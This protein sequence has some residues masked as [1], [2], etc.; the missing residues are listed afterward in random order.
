MKTNNKIQ[1]LVVILL[2]ALSLN[3]LA[4]GLFLIVDPSGTALQIPVELL[5]GTPF[6]SYLIP[7]IILF[8]TNG[9]SSL[10]IAIMTI[11]KVKHYPLLIILQGCVLLA[12]LSSELILNRE[13]FHPVLHYPLFVVGVLLIIAG[14]FVERKGLEIFARM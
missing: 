9:I 10:V 14:F 8:L 4:G 11:K 6:S 5:E 13:F 3:A 1:L 12:W 2:L 7:G